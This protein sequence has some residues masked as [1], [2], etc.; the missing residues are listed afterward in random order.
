MVVSVKDVSPSYWRARPFSA[1]VLPF[2]GMLPYNNNNNYL[3]NEERWLPQISET[4]LDIMILLINSDSPSNLALNTYFYKYIFN[5][6]Y[7]G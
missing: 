1:L 5:H 6:Q 4:K 2:R 3:M 7:A